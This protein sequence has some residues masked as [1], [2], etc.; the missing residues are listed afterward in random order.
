MTKLSELNLKYKWGMAHGW[1]S[2]ANL[3]FDIP[4]ELHAPLS[5]LTATV[6]VC[7]YSGYPCHGALFDRGAETPLVRSTGGVC[8]AWL[9]PS[10]WKY[11]KYTELLFLWYSGYEGQKIPS[12]FKEW[13]F[14]ERNPMWET[15]ISKLDIQ[16]YPFIKSPEIN[17]I[18]I[19]N[20]PD[21][22]FPAFL[23]WLKLFRPFTEAFGRSSMWDYLD[24]FEMNATDKAFFCQLFIR[25]NN[26][27]IPRI[28]YDT[29]GIFIRGSYVFS[30]LTESYKRWITAKPWAEDEA[31]KKYKKSREGNY[32]NYW[33]GN[34]PSRLDNTTWVEDPG[35]NNELI[36][37][38][39]NA[40]RPDLV[41]KPTELNSRWSKAIESTSLFQ[42]DGTPIHKFFGN[43]ALPFEERD[44]DKLVWFFYEQCKNAVKEAA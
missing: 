11:T 1:S 5:K 25:R 8:Y 36:Q 23:S 33:F 32:D 44:F 9:F 21:V 10:Y 31:N 38:V 6:P 42:D 28:Y 18:H 14:S 41:K 39:L 2:Y 22:H 30:H 29:H 40:V 43:R 12:D 7:N 3:E 37:S 34:W 27:F 15:C 19:K 17:I 4:E 20:I 35:V 16:V 13:I 24:K 26:T